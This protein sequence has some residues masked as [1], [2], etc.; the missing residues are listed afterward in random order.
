MMKSSPQLLAASDFGARASALMCAEHEPRC[1]L[2]IGRK[3]VIFRSL[4]SAPIQPLVLRA[5]VREAKALF[6][7][8]REAI[9]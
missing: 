7:R 3:A 6:E 4:L 5:F 2:C 9:R 1:M 8:P